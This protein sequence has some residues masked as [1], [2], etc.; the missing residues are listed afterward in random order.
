[1]TG[2]QSAFLVISGPVGVGKTTIGTEL[3]SILERRLI[4]HSFIDLDG[5]AQTYPRTPDDPFGNKIALSNLSLVWANCLKHG[6]KNLI[7]ARVVETAADVEKLGQATGISKITVCQLYAPD[8]T[9]LMR[10]RSREIGSDREWHERRSLELARQLE[11]TDFAD[12]LVDTEAR[13]P[14]DIAEEIAGK[15]GWS[16]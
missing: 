8:S 7:V 9:L 1:M 3:S 12:F 11:Q 2:N 14:A 16:G 4:A 15:V 10:V 6:S 13:E 5:L